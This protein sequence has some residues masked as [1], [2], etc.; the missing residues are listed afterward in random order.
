MGKGGTFRR[1]AP[2]PPGNGR[3]QPEP[4]RPA[5]TGSPRAT[6]AYLHDLRPLLVSAADLR[7]SFVREIGG[8]MD[9]SGRSSRLLMAQAAGRAGRDHSGY[10]R[11][12]KAQVDALLPPATCLACHVAVQRWLERHVDASQV[13]TEV[14][15]SGDL[16][17]M[18]ETQRLLAEARHFARQLN[19]EYS[20]L[21]EELRQRVKAA[22]RRARG[23]APRAQ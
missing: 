17:R 4:F 10:F 12:L 13:M 11:K 20:R 14:G 18:H 9:D 3:A 6:A 5:S 1:R 8:L 21:V 22:S 23:R 19:A 15:R 16:S 7:R 2:P